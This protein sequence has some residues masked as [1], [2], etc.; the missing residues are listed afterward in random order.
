MKSRARVQAFTSGDNS[1]LLGRRSAYDSRSRGF[2]QIGC[3]IRFTRVRARE[4]DL[5]IRRELI[6]HSS[7]GRLYRT[8]YGLYCRYW[9]SA[10]SWV[11][12]KSNGLVLPELLKYWW[13]RMRFPLHFFLLFNIQIC[14]PVLWLL[15]WFEAHAQNEMVHL[16]SA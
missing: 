6:G 13:S 10:R 4:G 12:A 14:S 9:I 7:E 2:M 1:Q 15:R 11:L 3:L 16:C 5:S 8:L